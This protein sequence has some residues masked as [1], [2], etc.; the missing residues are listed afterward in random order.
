MLGQLRF[1]AELYTARVSG[2]PAISARPR[3][4][5]LA[6]ILSKR[7]QERQDALAHGAGHVQVR[8]VENVDQGATGSNALNDLD[9]DV[10]DPSAAIAFSSC[11]PPIVLRPDAFSWKT[12]SQPSATS[13]PAWTS[14][15]SQA[16][17]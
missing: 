13:A 15:R 12:R 8:L 5:P 11:V 6:L 14:P 17:A 4:D 10:A 9:Q 7:A 1:A 16:R 2:L 3:H